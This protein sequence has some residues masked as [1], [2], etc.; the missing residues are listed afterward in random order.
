MKFANSLRDLPDDLGAVFRLRYVS[1][2][3]QVTTYHIA[4]DCV[5]DMVRF[6][7]D[8]GYTIESLC[9]IK[10]EPM[11]VTLAEMMLPDE[12]DSVR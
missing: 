10:V 5:K 6:C 7:M 8:R 2:H 3:R 11:N 12:A 1:K 9:R 4:V